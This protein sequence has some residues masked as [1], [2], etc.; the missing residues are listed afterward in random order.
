[1]TLSWSTTGAAS[2]SIDNGV[3]P[4]STS[5]NTTVTPAATTIYSLSATGAGGTSTRTAQ[6]IINAHP[7]AV[8]TTLGTPGVTGTT[9]GAASVAL[10]N[11]P[12]AVGL[13]GGGNIYVVDSGNHTIRKIDPSG[14]TVT[15]LGQP[16]KSGFLDGFRNAALFDFTGFSGGMLVF[17]DG[18]M[19]IY[20]HS[21]Y[22]RI[23]DAKGNVSTCKLASCAPRLFVIGMASDASGSNFYEAESAKNRITRTLKGETTALPFAG[24]GTAGF[25]D[26]QGTA[27]AF[28]NPR[29]LAIDPSGNLYVGDTGNNAVRK[30]TPG[31]LVTTLAKGF[32]F[33]CCG[34]M[35]AVDKQG[36]V[37]VADSGSNTIKR[38]TAAGIV[39]TLIG[40]GGAG[41]GS[42]E[43]VLA[44]FQSPNGIAIDPNGGLVIS[45]TGNGTIRKTTPVAA[46]TT[47]RRAAGK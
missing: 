47:R 41:S 33:G 9:D 24:S 6:V 39:Q 14:L 13:D 4:V 2:A 21:N 18:S 22:K 35:V 25:L 38:I 23:I 40:S 1:V 5:G 17:T 19:V 29:G 32:S 7:P 42:G 36:N 45:D 26:G 30:I 27:A 12:A 37:Y 34:G 16:G 44:S 15:W 28:N 11:Q 20:D 46:T 8:V 10:F 31:G 43:G 3:G